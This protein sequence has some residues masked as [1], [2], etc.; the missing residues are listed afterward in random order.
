MIVH[1]ILNQR[2]SGQCPAEWFLLT[3]IL[4]SGGTS[5]VTID[6]MNGLRICY[7]NSQI[8]T[9]KSI[10]LEEMYERRMAK[11][12][13]EIQT[14]ASNLRSVDSADGVEPEEYYKFI[15]VVMF[16]NYCKNFWAAEQKMGKKFT[17]TID[18]TTL[19]CRQL[20]TL[21]KIIKKVFALDCPPT[22]SY[23]RDFFS[24]EGPL[25]A[26]IAEPFVVNGKLRTMEEYRK[27]GNRSPKEN[28]I[29]AV[30]YLFTLA[31]PNDDKIHLNDDPRSCL[32]VL[33]LFLSHRL[34]QIAYKQVKI[35]AIATPRAVKKMNFVEAY[36]AV[37][38]EAESVNII[39]TLRWDEKND[40]PFK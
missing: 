12:R 38:T 24:L 22:Y 3:E 26:G 29:C 14:M 20:D 2:T 36:R 39:S 40:F 19:M 4:K 16:D 27:F 7:S 11:L 30:Y 21:K 33:K 1:M 23:I 18:S 31:P 37:P 5:G 9:G 35:T 10:Q 15:Y 8:L 34:V 32:A 13:E 17:S 28:Q 25:E 6:T